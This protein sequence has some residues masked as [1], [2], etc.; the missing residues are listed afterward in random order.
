MKLTRLGRARTRRPCT[1]S[2][3][4]SRSGE[5]TTT[6][7]R[8]APDLLDRLLDRAER[9][10][11][12]ARGSCS[13]SSW[14]SSR[15]SGTRIP[16]AAARSRSTCRARTSVSRLTRSPGTR[17]PSVVTARVC[18]MRATSKPSSVSAATVR[19]TPATEIE[20]FSTTKR[21]SVRPAPRTRMRAPSPSGAT[22]RSRRR[23]RRGPARCGRRAAR[24]RAA[25]VLE[26]HAVARPRAPPSV[27]RLERLG[28]GVEGQRRRGRRSTAVRQQPET[29]IESPSA[30]SGASRGARM[31]QARAL[32]AATSA[33]TTSPT[34]STIPVNIDRHRVVAQL[35]VDEDVRADPL[36]AQAVQ[37]P[38]RR[39]AG[40]RPAVEHGPP[41][42][43]E[44]R[45]A[46]NSAT[47][48]TRPS[49]I[50]AQASSRRPRTAGDVTRRAAERRSASP[51]LSASSALA[52]GR[53]GPGRSR[54][55]HQHR[56]ALGVDG[57]SGGPASTS[58]RPA[59]PVED[60]PQR[61][62]LGRRLGVPRR[63][64]GWSAARCRSRRPPRP[65]PPASR[66]PPARLSGE[67]IQRLSPLAVADPAVEA[68]GQ[69]EQHVGRPVDG[70]HPEAR[71]SGGGR[72][73]RS[74]LGQLDLDAGL[75]Q[76]GE[77][78]ARRPSPVG[79]AGGAD[80]PGDAGVDQ[81]VGARR[82]AAVVAAG[83]ERDVGRRPAA[84]PCC[85]RR[86]RRL[87]VPLPGPLR[88][89]P[90]RQDTSALTITQP[91]T[92]SGSAVRRPR[93]AS[94]SVRSSRRSSS[95]FTA[96]VRG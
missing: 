51:A 70:V 73:A 11:W 57:S 62:A 94:S 32:G 2:P 77:A 44:E 20:P 93:R 21:R 39:P 61:L 48:S 36:G 43:A 54:A 14:T 19:L 17:S 12:M 86:A 34:S 91:T 30:A 6:T 60:H 10:R 47:R 45:G 31:A 1:R 74:R 50:S 41:V 9:R 29:A 25:D 92:G 79:I 15:V 26:V 13:G 42:V 83:L 18:G 35:A 3:S 78:L 23:R 46:R 71:R 27:V 67:E 52:P 4:F 81:R 5:S 89:S 95:R 38:A 68:G 80:H 63:Q 16:P 64:L 56:P 33:A 65:S 76:P 55:R 7:M 40:R 24:R 84:D 87:G 49:R 58:G 82:L 53:A 75:A 85:R 59:A 66:A 90:R 96:R 37:A 8:P 69:L 22:A 28:H 88:A 72:A